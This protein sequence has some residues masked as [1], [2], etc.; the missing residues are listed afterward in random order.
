M[1]PH[2]LLAKLAATVPSHRRSDPSEPVGLCVHE[3][4]EASDECRVLG[5]FYSNY[6]DVPATAGCVDCREDGTCDH[7]P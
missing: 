1:T 6:H 4:D 5:V 2:Q 3:P 7:H